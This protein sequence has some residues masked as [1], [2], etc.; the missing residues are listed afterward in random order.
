M[1][2]LLEHFPVKFEPARPS[3]LWIHWNIPPGY[4]IAWN[5]TNFKINQYL[6]VKHV[7]LATKLRLEMDAVSE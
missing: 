4:C 3:K 1:F 2:L 6:E 5:N 7:L